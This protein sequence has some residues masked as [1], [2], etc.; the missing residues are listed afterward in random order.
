MSLVAKKREKRNA[1]SPQRD[2]GFLK[3]AVLRH[4]AANLRRSWRNSPRDAFV[5][6]TF[7]VEGVIV[8]II[9]CILGLINLLFIRT[10][11][12]SLAWSTHD[13]PGGVLIIAAIGLA[14]L[15]F[16]D[17]KLKQYEPPPGMAI[18]YDTSRGRVFVYVSFASGFIVL[19][20]AL[21][22]T[23]FINRSFPTS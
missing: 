3:R 13:K 21:T 11:F 7:Q 18:L 15:I 14:C 5:D 2:D 17:R 12:P 22:A 9:A 4:Y 6:A 1:S 19:A 8:M 16:V 10:I 23:Y 20:L